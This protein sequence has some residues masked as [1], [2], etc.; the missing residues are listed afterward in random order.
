MKTFAAGIMVP[1][2]YIWPINSNLYLQA[3][4]TLVQDAHS[5]GLE[6]Y[7]SNFAND[8]YGMSYNYS[9]DPIREYLQFVDKDFAVDGILTDFSVTASEAIACYAQNNVSTSAKAGKTLIISHN[10]AS[11]DY[12]GSTDIAYEAAI[13]DGVDYIDC[14]VQITKDGV[15]ICRESPDLTIGTN[16]VSNSV[17]YPTRLK[18]VSDINKMAV[19]ATPSTNGAPGIFTFDLTWKEIQS[20]KPSIFSPFTVGFSLLRNPAE[21][22]AGKYMNLSAFLEFAQSQKNVRVIINIQN[23][24]AIALARNLSIVDPVISA[25]NKS[26]YNSMTNR[27]MIQSDDSAVLMKF[28]QLTKFKLVYSVEETDVSIPDSTI[29]EIKAFSD[30][31]VIRRETVFPASSSYLLGV[32]DTV[33]RMHNY[34]MSVFIFLLRNEFAALAFDYIAD[35]TLEIHSYVSL[36]K[37]DG[38]ITD[39]PATARAYMG[40]VCLGRR[41]GTQYSMYL[42]VPGAIETA[43]SPTSMPP[44][45]A[46]APVLSSVAEPPLPNVVEASAP[47]TASSPPNVPA[48][49]PTKPSNACRS[50]HSLSVSL[51]IGLFMLF[52]C[53]N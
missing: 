15:P 33:E 27:I 12:P 36:A 9:Y 2:D 24:R 35:P 45:L 41:R 19:T 53:C 11:G 26:G 30:A 28:K 6:I 16:I 31:V 1:K 17:F 52:L 37:V 38:L 39:F 5:A 21:A 47:G 40:N 23:A 4:T 48:V 42:S 49:S 51:L 10:G 44:A 32:T 3:P 18:T 7:A 34:N 13:S 29:K 46:P 20:L 43:M 14:S 8:E 50:M 25:L 22:S